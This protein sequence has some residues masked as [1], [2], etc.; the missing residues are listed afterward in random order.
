MHKEFNVIEIIGF[1]PSVWL[2]P[3]A[4]VLPNS[5][6]E[7]AHLPGSG[8]EALAVEPGNLVCTLQPVRVE[9][10]EISLLNFSCQI[11]AVQR[12][13][14][15]SDT[16]DGCYWCQE[17]GHLQAVQDVFCHRCTSG[18]FCYFQDLRKR[19]QSGVQQGQ[20]HLTGTRL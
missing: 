16:F 3:T 9:F 14:Q 11:N 17:N 15:L 6:H 18:G 19:S 10:C 7:V 13:E 5:L 20:V 12:L 8:Q 1:L 2:V 4:T